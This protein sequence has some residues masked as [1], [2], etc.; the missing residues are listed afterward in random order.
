MYDVIVAGVGSMGAAACEAI[1][2]RGAKVL[3]LERFG[4]PN[5]MGAHS[6][7][8]RI[9]R[10]AYYEHP[11]YVPLLIRSGQLWEDLQRRSGVKLLHTTGVL[12]VS[13]P[14][15][16]LVRKSRESAEAHGIACE[17]LE[18]AALRRRFPQFT[19]PA[20]HTG[21]LER[22][23]GFLL[24]EAGVAAM[25]HQAML[26]GADLRGREGVESWTAEDGS[27]RVRTS[28]GEYR[29][30]RLILSGG[31]WNG[32]LIGDLGVPVTITRQTLWWFRPKACEK[33]S[34]AAFPCW[35]IER[36][37]GALYY[38]FPL[39][40]TRPGLKVAL[41]AA[42]PA[43]DPEKADRTPTAREEAA[44][45]ECLRRFIPE[46]D[47]PVLSSAVCFY[48]NSP[49]GHFILDRHP[50]HEQ[51]LVATGFS[52]HGFK[53]AP[54]IGE[55]LAQLALDGSTDLPVGF[56]GLAR[57]REGDGAR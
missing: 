14:G 38:G 22:L 8:S 32:P 28:E 1:A 51:V 56:L 5:T 36:Q 9:F 10:R 27:V 46:G 50:V 13:P 35:A 52:G 37:P 23:G 20:D 3:G 21:L 11:D 41:H 40:P 45:R 19:L 42:G 34:A 33:F 43:V 2:R 53:F 57:F 44:V 16:E 29:A 25:A 12:Y 7:A 55:A 30:R 39:T 54:V 18:P 24:P 15:G 47:G 4:I 6:G 49:D 17:P 48:D 31:P 26:A